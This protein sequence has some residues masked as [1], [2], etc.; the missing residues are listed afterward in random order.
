M[1]PQDHVMLIAERIH[2]S[3][4]LVQIGRDALEVVIGNLLI[5][6]GTV[7]TMMRKPFFR[8]RH[9]NALGGMSMR[10]EMRILSR[11]MNGGMNR[12]A[13]SIHPPRHVHDLVAVKVNLDKIGD[14]NLVVLETERV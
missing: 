14:G 8:A 12:K 1:V 7:E 6:H 5:E 9:R 10:D 3:C 11:G 4:P 13:R 2:Q